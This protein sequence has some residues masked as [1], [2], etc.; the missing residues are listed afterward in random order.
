M[1]WNGGARYIVLNGKP[2]TKE[3]IQAVENEHEVMQEYN[4]SETDNVGTVNSVNGDID[5]SWEACIDPNTGDTYYYN[6]ITLETSWTLP[7]SASTATC[8]T[9]PTPPTAYEE[10]TYPSSS[11]PPMSDSLLPPESATS[12]ATSSAGTS[13]SSRPQS[14]RLLARPPSIRA[15]PRIPSQPRMEALISPH[16]SAQCDTLPTYY[17]EET[18]AAFDHKTSTSNP[19]EVSN[20]QSRKAVDERTEEKKVKVCVSLSLDY[21]VF[22][23]YVNMF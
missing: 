9:T 15:M 14:V 23:S 2:S 17:S 8:P 16:S 13:T 12:S 1:R 7:L 11:L 19:M 10:P 22:S 6:L 21:V 5:E 3:S 4:P 20:E 18:S